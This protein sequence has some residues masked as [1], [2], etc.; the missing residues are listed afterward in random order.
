MTAA[1]KNYL[2]K[3]IK[4]LQPKYL[5]GIIEMMQDMNSSDNQ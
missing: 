1:E 3:N 4:L 5:H 2:G